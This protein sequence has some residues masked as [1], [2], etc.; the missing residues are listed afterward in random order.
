MGEV[1][2]IKEGEIIRMSESQAVEEDLFVLRRVME[3]IKEQTSSEPGRVEEFKRIEGS[4]PLENW[5]KGDTSYKK[6]NVLNSL[7][8]NFHWEVSRKRRLKGWTRKQVADEVGVSEEDIKTVELGGLP[9]DDYI[10]I[11]KLE[12]LFGFT[13]RKEGAVGTSGPT[14]SELQKMNESRV[15][16]A[17]GRVHRGESQKHFEEKKSERVSA[18]EV[19]TGNDIEIID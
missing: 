15:N 4:S 19:L 10:L 12:N 5:R 11:S 9:S 3:P 2:V 13:L 16:D 18:R 6:N 14:L 17:I 7:K 1:E 8:Q